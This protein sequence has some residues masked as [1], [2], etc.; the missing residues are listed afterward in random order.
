MTRQL[1]LTFAA[2]L[3]FAAATPSIAFDGSH[4]PWQET[5][6]DNGIYR[7]TNNPDVR[8]DT[9]TGRKAVPGRAAAAQAE[10]DANERSVISRP[11]STLVD[12]HRTLD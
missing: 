6:E 10:N 1:P 9:N 7:N 3:A 12:P 2:L 5:G 8:F 11:D 4:G